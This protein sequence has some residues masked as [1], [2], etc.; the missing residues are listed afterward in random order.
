MNYDANLKETQRD[1]FEFDIIIGIKLV[2]FT[3]KSQDLA[4]NWYEN[5]IIGTGR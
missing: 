4:F 3:L 2:L 5:I 1:M